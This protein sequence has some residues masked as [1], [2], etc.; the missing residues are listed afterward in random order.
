MKVILHNAFLIEEAFVI[1]F[2]SVSRPLGRALCPFYSKMPDTAFSGNS[3]GNL[4]KDPWDILVILFI[5]S[6]MKAIVIISNCT[7]QLPFFVT[8]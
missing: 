7:L 5:S 4:A 3:L 6:T 2:I 1:T 8:C